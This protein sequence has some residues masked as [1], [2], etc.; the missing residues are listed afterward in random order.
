MEYCLC[1]DPFC[2]YLTMKSVTKNIHTAS[3][4]KKYCKTLMGNI[5]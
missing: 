2:V 5:H 3:A 4:Q 1:T